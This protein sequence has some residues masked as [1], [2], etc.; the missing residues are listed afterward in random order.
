MK[1]Y[2]TDS[3]GSTA[4]VEVVNGG[5]RLKVSNAYGQR[6]YDKVLKSMTSC[7][8]VM[9]QMSDGSMKELK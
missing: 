2:Y 4:S 8:R 6:H 7:K 3:Y 1:T 5:Y 9:T